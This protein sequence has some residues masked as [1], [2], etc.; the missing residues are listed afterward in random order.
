MGVF[1]FMPRDIEVALTVIFEKEIILQR[2]IEQAKLLLLS[3]YDYSPLLAFRSVDRYNCGRIDCLNL[4]VFMKACEYHNLHENDVMA[5]IR[6]IDTNGDACLDFN[7]FCEFLKPLDSLV[8]LKPPGPMPPPPHCF[9]PGPVPPPMKPHGY[10]RESSPLRGTS[11]PTR[12]N[13]DPFAMCMPPPVLPPVPPRGHVVY[14]TAPGTKEER[15]VLRI[16]EEDE[17]IGAL[18]EQCKLERELE[19]FKISLVQKC[20][21]NLFD[22][23][24]IFDPSR[25]G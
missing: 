24:N 18:R 21:F 3:R 19:S 6:R 25:I 22:A 1:E 10:P 12:K 4:G 16:G 15:P 20:D 13:T 9:S 17:L 8:G 2:Q 5:I 14:V 11:S 23:F 7:E